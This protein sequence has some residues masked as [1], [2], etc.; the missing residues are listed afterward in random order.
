M[1]LL[2][3]PSSRAIK[4]KSSISALMSLI[5]LQSIT[6]NSRTIQINPQ[7]WGIRQPLLNFNRNRNQYTR[8]ISL[9]KLQRHWLKINCQ[10]KKEKCLSL[11]FCKQSR[12]W[13]M[14]SQPSHLFNCIRHIASCVK[15]SKPLTFAKLAL[16]AAVKP[17]RD[18]TTS[19][20]S[21][22]MSTFSVLSV[23]PEILSQ[24]RIASRLTNGNHIPLPRSSA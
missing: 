8:S 19:A 15:N 17:L 3:S 4:E 20:L 14:I 13:F 1:P 10:G 2:L 23:R 5:N 11:T 12:M 18:H 21:V 9:Q 16:N 6:Q 24:I 22:P 7:S